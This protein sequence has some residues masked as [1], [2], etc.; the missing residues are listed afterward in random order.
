MLPATCCLQHVAKY[1]HQSRPTPRQQLATIDNML[2]ATCCLQYVAKCCHCIVRP[3]DKNCLLPS[4]ARRSTASGKIS[5]SIRATS[6]VCFQFEGVCLV[7]EWSNDKTIM[8]I[9]DYR[10][11]EILWNHR[12]KDFKNNRKKLDILQ[13]LSE[14]YGN[15]IIALKKKIKNLRTQFHREHKAIT[16]TTSGQ[17]AIKKNKW[18]Y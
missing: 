18:C 16:N 12:L 5:N 2:P 10:N 7:M 1:C 17:S 14:K 8:F 4:V 6:N 11:S 13:N 15:D 9:E 3:C